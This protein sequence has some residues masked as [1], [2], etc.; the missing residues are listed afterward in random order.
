VKNSSI[1]VNVRR[2]ILA[3]KRPQPGI[4]GRKADTVLKASKKWR[5]QKQM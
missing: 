2:E 4:L 5:P 3:K 1:V